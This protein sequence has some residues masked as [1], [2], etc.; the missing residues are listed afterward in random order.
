[1]KQESVSERA[2]DRVRPAAGRDERVSMVT[3]CCCCGVG[4]KKSHRKSVPDDDKK[5]LISNGSKRSRPVSGDS[6][7]SN[8]TVGSPPHNYE[9]ECDARL[10]GGQQRQ[11]DNDDHR[12]RAAARA[13]V[14]KVNERAGQ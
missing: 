14:V 11:Q 12:V 10:E 4:G 13:L 8:S 3:R 2:I 9:D 7:V 1:M 6:A 5:R